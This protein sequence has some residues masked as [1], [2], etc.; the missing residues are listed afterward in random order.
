MGALT[1]APL[2][3]PAPVAGSPAGQPTDKQILDEFGKRLD[4]H[5]KVVAQIAE[6]KARGVVDSAKLELEAKLSAAQTATIQKLVAD[7]AAVKQRVSRPPGGM[8]PGDGGQNSIGRE[9][10]LSDAFK[11][12]N[13]TGGG[14]GFRIAHTMKKTLDRRA[15]SGGGGVEPLAAGATITEG[16]SGLVIYPRRVAWV[17]PPEFPMYMRDL[18]DVVPL[19]GTNA[20][21]YVIETWT[22]NN[23]GYQVLEGDRK[24]QSGVTYTDKTAVVRTIAHFVKISK[25]MLADVPAVETSINQRL[26][27]YVLLFEDKEILYGDNSAGHLNGIVT[28]ATT[29]VAPP[30]IAAAVTTAM[31][32]IAAAIA[33]C[34]A[35]GYLPTAVVLN[36]V[37]WAGQQLVKST[38]GLY[39]LGGP[40]SVAG[41]TLW[42]LPVVTTPNM[43]AGQFLVGSFPGNAALFDR[44]AVTVEIS[45]ENEDDFVKNLATIRCEERVALAVYVPLAFIKGNMTSPFLASAEGVRTGEPHPKKA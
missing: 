6:E 42:G 21:E 10:T 35:N 43:A 16:G 9:F 15:G 45:F 27:Y 32:A 3:E 34:T 1:T 30:S 28:Q 11:N 33:Q 40:Q 18:L 31:D 14:R 25:Q 2:T 44:Q 20:V 41:K 12:A 7:V 5:K 37:D 8:F 36:P 4:E 26:V 19:D 23:A 39:I 38:Q 13:L 29:Y 24:G 17:T 22:P